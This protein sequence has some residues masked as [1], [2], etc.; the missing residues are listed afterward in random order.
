MAAQAI[1]VLVATG[2]HRPNE[3]RELHELVGD[4]WVLQTVDVVNNSWGFDRPFDDNKLDPFAQQFTQAIEDAV[5][6]Q[7]DESKACIF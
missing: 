3:G 2:L 4:D 1:T 6:A 7:W 5:Q